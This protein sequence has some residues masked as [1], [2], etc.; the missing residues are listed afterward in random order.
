MKIRE[1]VELLEQLPVPTRR[2]CRKLWSWPNRRMVLG[3]G[4]RFAPEREEWGHSYKGAQGDFLGSGN[5]HLG[6]GGVEYTHLSKLTELCS[7]KTYA[8]CNLYLN[9]S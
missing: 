8:F 4:A 9:F 7:F 6:G 2:L 5:L 1:L 3:I